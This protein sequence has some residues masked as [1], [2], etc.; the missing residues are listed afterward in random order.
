[1]EPGTHGFLELCQGILSPTFD[2]FQVLLRRL[3]A[4]IEAFQTVQKYLERVEDSILKK[5]WALGGTN[6]RLRQACL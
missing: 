3:K 5:N 1:L 2:L 6:D 4:L